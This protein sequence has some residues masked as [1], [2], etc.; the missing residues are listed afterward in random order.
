MKI[1]RTP[2]T[3]TLSRYGSGS[4]GIPQGKVAQGVFP[5]AVSLA[6]GIPNAACMTC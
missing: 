4:A 5:G 3:A 6:T 2:G 1:R